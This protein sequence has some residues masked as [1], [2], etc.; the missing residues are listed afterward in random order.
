MHTV[1]IR[2]LAALAVGALIGFA[3]PA[4]AQAWHYPAMQ[5]ASQEPNEIN[6]LIAGFG[7]DRPLIG[8]G[9]SRAL[10]LAR[11][12]FTSQLCHQFEDLPEPRC[13]NGMAFRLQAS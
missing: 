9:D 2:T 4:R 1:R 8:D 11:S 3:A 6:V 10:D 7:G 13:A 12:G 5:P